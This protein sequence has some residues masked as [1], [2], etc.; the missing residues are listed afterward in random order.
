MSRKIRE[1]AATRR[2]LAE[3]TDAMLRLL[4]PMNWDRNDRLASPLPF[5]NLKSQIYN[6]AAPCPMT[7][8]PQNYCCRIYF[9][10][11]FSAMREFMSFICKQQSLF[12]SK[13]CLP[14][15]NLNFTNPL[16]IFLQKSGL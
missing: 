16:T 4:L 2:Q 14:A 7:L 1:T 15:Y 6:F 12:L 8:D 11:L 5:R 13:I 10:R 3:E 9:L